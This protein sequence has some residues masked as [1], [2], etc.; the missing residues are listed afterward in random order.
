MISTFEK[1]IFYYRSRIKKY[2][3]SK[4]DVTQYVSF[5]F[6]FLSQATK[7]SMDPS[8]HFKICLKNIYLPQQVQVPWFPPSPLCW[9][10]SQQQHC[11]DSHQ[12]YIDCL[13]TVKEGWDLFYFWI[14]RICSRLDGFSGMDT[15]WDIWPRAAFWVYIHSLLNANGRYLRDCNPPSFIMK[16]KLDIISSIRKMSWVCYIRIA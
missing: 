15:R 16:P 10:Y 9:W 3:Y 1:L 6:G 11:Q 12:L 8:E 13:Y 7:W 4:N 14:Q 5:L 2:C